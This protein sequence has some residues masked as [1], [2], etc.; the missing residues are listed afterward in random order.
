MATLMRLPILGELFWALYTRP[1]R[2]SEDIRGHMAF[3]GHRRALL[4]TVRHGPFGELTEVY[5]RVGKHE[6]PTMLIWGR[7]DEAIPLGVST[8]VLEAIPHTEFHAIDEAGHKPQCD[9]PDVVNPL[10]IEFLGR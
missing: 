5:E 4:S 9:R 1:E 10:L 7:E 3:E 8:R 2:F 6:R